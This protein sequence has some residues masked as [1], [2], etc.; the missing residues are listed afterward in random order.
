MSFSSGKCYITFEISYIIHTLFLIIIIFVQMSKKL[1]FIFSL[2]FTVL[3]ISPWAFGEEHDNIPPRLAGKLIFSRAA[4]S[5]DFPPLKL[6]Q[7]AL[8]GYEMLI[9]E[10]SIRRPEVITI[11][12]FSLP[13]DKKRLWVLDLINGKVLFRCLVSHGRNSGEIMAENFSNTPGSNASSPGFYATGET[14]IGKHGLSLALDGLETGIND[15]A[16]ERAIVIHG[17]DYVS[18]DFIRKYGRLGR[19]FGCPAVPVEL[20]KEIIQ[21]IKGGSCLFIYVPEKSYTSNS[22]IITRITSIIKG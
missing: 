1:L 11:I 17:A 18:T 2:F 15:K 13:S 22:Q 5:S 16:R 14:Y 12:D 20:S 4:D 21:T 6:L 8:A 3:A 19:S 9:E 10:Q 7:T